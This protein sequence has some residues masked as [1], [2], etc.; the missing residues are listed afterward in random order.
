MTPSVPPNVPSFAE[1]AATN[2]PL[3]RWSIVAMSVCTLFDPLL[4]PFL[5]FGAPL[6]FA[7][8]YCLTLRI[9]GLK[10]E[11]IHTRRPQ[12]FSLSYWLI[13][14]NLHVY[15]P[16]TLGFDEY[17]R[18]HLCHHGYTNTSRDPDYLLV[19]DGKLNAWL[20][21][22]FTPEHW[23]FF[24]VRRRMVSKDFWFLYSLRLAFLAFAVSQI[25]FASYLL[26]F[27]LPS[28]LAY[29]FG[30]LIFA[31]ECHIDENDVR[32]IFNVELRWPIVQKVLRVA[33]GPFTYN[34][35]FFH[36]VHHR[37]PRVSSVHLERIAPSVDHLFVTRELP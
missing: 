16:F 34:G 36:A 7:L 20:R 4:I 8:N 37:F 10:H 13:R 1:L 23:F 12:G 3:M 21:L 31:L 35:T 22:P 2:T 15:S 29:L 19:K 26:Y 5:P 30:F 28:K 14:M 27:L 25:G 11:L 32:G 6:V 17:K 9:I 18:L 24:A 33:A